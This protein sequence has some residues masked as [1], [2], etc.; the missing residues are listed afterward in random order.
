MIFA[1]W[2]FETPIIPKF[3]GGNDFYKTNHSKIH[4]IRQITPDFL[5]FFTFYNGNW[6]NWTEIPHFFQFNPPPVVLYPPVVTRFE[7]RKTK[8]LALGTVLIFSGSWRPSYKVSIGQKWRQFSA[9]LHH[10]YHEIPAYGLD[11]ALK[12]ALLRSCYTSIFGGLSSFLFISKK[13]LLSVG[14][15]QVLLV[16]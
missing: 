9:H 1:Q 11:C 6:N 16:L 15:V 13:S 2:D 3:W 14:S 8:Q 12:E 5:N 7:A 10:L 4:E